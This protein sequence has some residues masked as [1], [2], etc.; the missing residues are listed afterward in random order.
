MEREIK[1][2]SHYYYYRSIRVY[3][4]VREPYEFNASIHYCVL[5]FLFCDS[6]KLIS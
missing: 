2:A 3:A 6:V 5:L 4:S 1:S